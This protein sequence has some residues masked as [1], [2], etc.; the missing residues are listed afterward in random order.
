VDSDL[1]DRVAAALG[2][3]PDWREVASRLRR[4]A[5]ARD[6]DPIWPILEVFDYELKN[7]SQV[8]QQESYGGPFGLGIESIAGTYPTPLKDVDDATLQ[9][10]QELFESI[11]DPVVRARIGDL[12]WVRRA[13]PA[14]HRRAVEAAEAYLVLADRQ[15]WH[16]MY[17]A[18][19]LTRALELAR[20]TN[21][22]DLLRG[23]IDRIAIAARTSMAAAEPQPG[24]ARR[25]IEGLC[26]LPRRE[27]PAELD[28]LL[29]LA[30]KTYEGN[31]FVFEV[32]IDLQ[33]SR[34][35]Q[36]PDRVKELARVEVA[37]WR[38]AAN[39]QP[40]LI[41]LRHLQR[42]LELA[43]AHGLRAE[44]EELRLAVQGIS[45]EEMGLQS[46]EAQIQ[47]PREQIERFLA[48]I[49]EGDS[50]K[51]WLAKFGAQCPL[52]E[53]RDKTVQDVEELIQAYPLQYL[54][55][56]VI[57]SPENVPIRVVS[58]EEDHRAAAIVEYDTRAI[59][60]WA[61]WAS[62][63]LSDV[64]AR[65][66]PTAGE[67]AEH[68]TTEIIPVEVAERVATAVD[69]FWEGR[70]DEALLILLP[71]LE[72]IVRELCRL[73]GLVILKEPTGSD[74]GEFL[75]LGSLLSSLKG[76]LPESRRCYLMT[77][78]T[79]P[80]GIN[81]RNRGLHGLIIP[82]SREEAALAIHV[83]CFLQQI[84]LTR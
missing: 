79:D 32:F 61:V 68:Y 73:L 43:R 70:Y 6:A 28:D 12:L 10:W 16:A 19:C 72:S 71:R 42:A 25:L 74:V 44:M 33:M 30:T 27:Q 39:G 57:L 18:Q 76:R 63:I 24:V 80:I 23:V 69:H 1:R 38:A 55:P 50:W 67:L 14:P 17:R 9:L 26:A 2:G 77:L 11:D 13:G 35:R 58:S 4:S 20:E 21:N 8:D 65:H 52:Q 83:A 54:M 15:G 45:E 29:D 37:R 47:I 3:E 84:Q 66:R 40:G 22:R 49:F 75:Q 78:L 46:V 82:G 41:R 48:G 81:L 56:K 51:D 5:G 36:D 60:L 62:E 64:A 7:S 34:V 53:P 59:M 31:P